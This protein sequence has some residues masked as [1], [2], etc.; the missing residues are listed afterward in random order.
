M[1]IKTCM[2]YLAAFA[3]TAGTICSTGASIR[4]Y[5]HDDFLALPTGNG[6]RGFD[7]TKGNILLDCG[8]VVTS[9]LVHHVQKLTYIVIDRPRSF[10]SR[11]LPD[12]WEIVFP[13]ASGGDRDVLASGPT[14]PPMPPAVSWRFMGVRYQ[15]RFSRLLLV[16][17]WYFLIASLAVAGT[18]FYRIIAIRRRLAGNR[19]AS[20]GY[21]LCATPDRCPECGTVPSRL[22][23]GNEKSARDAIHEVR[24]LNGTN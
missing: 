20:C 14:P 15:K 19:C 10:G 17:L 5:R 23:T 12:Y 18:S 3:G 11:E 16:P 7:V 24:E 13:E 9:P 2:I 22:S 21:D 8:T 1:K 4:S 6:V